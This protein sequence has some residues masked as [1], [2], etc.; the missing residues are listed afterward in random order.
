MY[1][2][3]EKISFLFFSGFRVFLSSPIFFQCILKNN[4]INYIYISRSI[5]SGMPCLGLLAKIN[6]KNLIRSEVF[7]RFL[8][9][10]SWFIFEMSFKFWFSHYLDFSRECTNLKS[11]STFREK[12]K[13]TR[14]G[15]QCWCFFFNF[16]FF[17]V[18]KLKK[19]SFIR[20]ISLQFSLGR[21]I[22]NCKKHPE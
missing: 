2:V 1:L 22:T 6:F 20:P 7:R 8:K 19:F 3:S 5:A 10:C 17:F 16:C 12:K 15:C 18:L 11:L 21:E 14:Q 9:F 4:T 13:K